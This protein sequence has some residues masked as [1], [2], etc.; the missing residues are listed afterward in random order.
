M[1]YVGQRPGW[2][3]GWPRRFISSI[4]WLDPAR[5]ELAAD[6]IVDEHVRVSQFPPNVSEG[7]L[8]TRGQRQRAFW[9]LCAST[10]QIASRQFAHGVLAGQVITR[11]VFVTSRVENVE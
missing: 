3:S 10:S 6:Q 11:V 1:S 8:L 9:G 5:L 4:S 7:P 2:A